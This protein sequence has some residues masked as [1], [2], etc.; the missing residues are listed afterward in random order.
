MDDGPASSFA[1]VVGYE[2]EVDKKLY[3]S[4]VVSLL[5]EGFSHPFMAKRVIQ[6]YQPGQAVT[7]HY[8][9][10]KPSDAFLTSPSKFLIFFPFGVSILCFVIAY[11]VG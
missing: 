2:Y 3:R 4:K 7:A 11:L 9:L 5:D 10:K 1:P 8:S 6:Q